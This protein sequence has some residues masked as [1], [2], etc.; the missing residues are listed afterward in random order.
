MATVKF[1]R[2]KTEEYSKGQSAD[3]NTIFFTKDTKQIIIG[4]QLYCA[5]A[6]E[7]EPEPIGPPN[8][9]IW[10]TSSDGQ[11]T[12]TNAEAFGATYLQDESTFDS[13]TGKGILKF[14]GDVTSIET[15]ALFNCSGLTSIEIPNS[16]TN[17]GDEAFSE[18]GSL[19]SVTIPN[20]V[21][22]IGSNAFANCNSLPSVTI[23][24]G[25]TSIG[26]GAF[27]ECGSLTSIEIPDSVISIGYGAFSGSSLTSVDVASNNP[28]YCSIDGVLFNKD[29]TTIIYYPDGKQ[30]A[31]TIPNSVTNIGDGAFASSSLTS[32]TIPNSVRSIGSNAFHYCN[33]LSYIRCDAE[34]PPDIVSNCFDNTNNCP[35]YV[36]DHL[37][38]EYREAWSAYASRI[39]ASSSGN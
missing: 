18:C 4:G 10:Y 26:D 14:D 11:I 17:I 23:G 1:D 28:I 3:Q 39:R 6:W 9:E 31:Y 29:K 33:S 27:Y 30:G 12:P 25:V 5:L 21:R 8:D 32:V 35:I 22:S 16:V 19:T 2:T 7:E 37:V 34:T 15:Y 38:D 13:D 36:L 24:N 20:S